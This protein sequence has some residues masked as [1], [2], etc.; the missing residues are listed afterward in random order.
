[1]FRL[2]RAFVAHQCNKKQACEMARYVRRKDLM[3]LCICADSSEPLSLTSAI[4]NNLV[5]WTIMWEGKPLWDCVYVQTHQSLCH[6]SA[7]SNNLVRWTIMWEGKPLWDCVYV[8]THQSLCH[9][10]AISNIILWNA[11]AHYVRR[12]ALMRPCI[13]VDSSEPLS[14]QCNK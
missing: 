3:R 2:I 14:H 8:Q 1:M 9:S 4:S 11:M 10:S 5:R 13:F 6:S 7:I 12:K